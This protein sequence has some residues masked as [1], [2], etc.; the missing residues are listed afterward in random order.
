MIK[1]DEKV[2]EDAIAHWK[3]NEGIVKIALKDD[4]FAMHKEIVIL[5]DGFETKE[6][7]STKKAIELMEYFY[8]QSFR[9]GYKHCKDDVKDD[10]GR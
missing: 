10:D 9:H 7:I 5:M 6:F 2:K 1:S 3:Y 8:I 4:I